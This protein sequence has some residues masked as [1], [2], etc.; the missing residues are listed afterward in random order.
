MPRANRHFLPGHVWH[1]THR[2]HQKSFLL[3]FARDR[4]RY[5]RWVFEAKKRFGL[6]VLNYIVTFNHVHL[7]VKDTGR[8]V[9]SQSM[10]LI[11]CRTA[12]EYN[13]RKGRQGAFWEDRYH[14]TAIQVDGKK[15]GHSD[16]LRLTFCFRPTRERG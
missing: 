12:Q 13:Q 14:A 4:H 10:Q 11:A 8:H 5:L 9:I 3:K 7:L 1:I 6:S 2:C 15:R 16:F